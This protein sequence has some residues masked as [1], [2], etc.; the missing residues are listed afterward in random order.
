M[1]PKDKKETSIWDEVN[2]GLVETQSNELNIIEFVETICDAFD[3]PLFLSQRI[4]LKA[5]YG[6]PFDDTVIYPYWNLTEKQLMDRWVA[7]RKTNWISPEKAL[8]L[9]NEERALEGEEPLDEFHYQEIVIQLGM[10]SGKSSLV[11]LVVAYEFYKMM[12]HPCPQQ[13]FADKGLK[14]PSS[15]PIYFPVLAS[16]ARQTKGTIYGY[17]KNYIEGSTFFQGYIKRNELTVTDLDIEFAAKH[18]I[19]ASGH[20]RADTMVGKTA[21]AAAFDELAMFS[22]DEGKASNAADVYSRVG[23]STSTFQHFSK[24]IALSSVKEEGDYMQEL[25]T[26]RWDRQAGGT[27]IF[28]ISTFDFNPLMTRSHPLIRGDYDKDPVA[29]QRDYENIRPGASQGFIN[30]RVVDLAAQIL[31]PDGVPVEIDPEANV[32]SR[33]VPIFRD[34]REGA[35]L[36][37]Y[38]SDETNADLIREYSGLE[39]SLL[40][41]APHGMITY[42]HCDP[43]GLRKD[44]FAFACGH[45]EMILG[46][47]MCTVI[48][49]C[50]EWRPRI[51]TKGAVAVVDFIN[52]EDVLIQVGRAR[53]MHR[54]SFDTWNSEGSIQKVFQAGIPT[55][56][57]SFSASSQF[58]M[59]LRLKESLN[60]GLIKI[61]NNPV[62]VEELKNLLLLNGS[63]VDH[64]KNKP[65]MVVGRTGTV[66]KDMA[67]C[68]AVVN[69][70]IAGQN[71][72][73]SRETTAQGTVGQS[74]TTIQAV[75]RT[76]TTSNIEWNFR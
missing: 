57:M 76:R 17:V 2:A 46:K 11:A 35:V 20:S 39:I 56:K 36:L 5:I 19:I 53:N 63:R 62:L 12:V 49:I 24:R 51:L 13:M 28:D 1:A 74:K 8:V 54:L 4:M 44:A 29:A 7:E 31:G 50:L 41:N 69:W 33:P 47:G 70:I 71:R 22:A 59:Y 38:E 34:R 45:G 10:R 9:M 3:V 43:G 42:G 60:A 75:G 64:P 18:L 72:Q 55:Y 67:D 61:P 66:G 26:K 48:D 65:S 15:S 32:V 14:L 40:Q 52:I 58:Q 16:S 6:L 21:K 68:I 27:L 30:P 37:D 25:V 23:R 73:F